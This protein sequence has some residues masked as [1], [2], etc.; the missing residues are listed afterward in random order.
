M[1]E[2]MSKKILNFAVGIM[3]TTQNLSIFQ[4]PLWV[5]IFALTA[6]VAWGFAYPLIKLGYAEFHIT[7]AMTGSKMLFA[8]IRFAIAGLLVVGM[9]VGGHK[10]FRVRSR[11]DWWF[12][13]PSSIRSVSLLWSSWHACSSR[14]TA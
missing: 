5:A 1:V 10:D 4:R 14:A 2:A 7:P 3:K 6:A 9:A 13:R 11:T 12:V 8:G